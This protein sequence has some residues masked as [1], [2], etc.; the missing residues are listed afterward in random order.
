MEDLKIVKSSQTPDNLNNY[1]P[2]VFLLHE[3][4]IVLALTYALENVAIVSELH[5]NAK[6]TEIAF[7]QWQTYH[8]EFDG[9]SKNAY[10]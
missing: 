5:H 6:D 3:L 8:R 2:N 9:S 7:R 1:L 10:L 4:F